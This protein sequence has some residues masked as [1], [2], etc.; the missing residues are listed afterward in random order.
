MITKELIDRIN[1]LSRK[2]RSEGLSLEE[3]EEQQR[4]RQQYIEGIKAQVRQNLEGIRYVD[5]NG[6]PCDPPKKVSKSKNNS[7]GHGCKCGCH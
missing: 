1:T 2:S 6:N 4:L 3:K 5:E 7:H